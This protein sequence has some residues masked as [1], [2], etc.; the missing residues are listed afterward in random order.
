MKYSEYFKLAAEYIVSGRPPE[1]DDLCQDFVDSTGSDTLRIV[2]EVAPDLRGVPAS[3][4]VLCILYCF[5]AAI[6]ED[7]GK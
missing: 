2:F 1:I 4:E 5:I 6:L 7:Q 3:N